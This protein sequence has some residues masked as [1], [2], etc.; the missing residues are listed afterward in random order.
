[1]RLFF[2]VALPDELR[3]RLAA[4][5]RELA[6]A[7]PL[8]RVGW[9]AP[10]NIHLTLRFQ[11][12]ASE[13]DV[14]LA[15]D[16]AREAAGLAAPLALELAGAGSFPGGRDPRVVW[17]G[18]REGPGLVALRALAGDLERGL[19]ARGFAAADHPFSPHVTLGRARPP[20]GRGA[21]GRE[22]HEPSDRTCTPGG[23]HELVR[24]L[25]R[26]AAFAGGTFDVPGFVL[27]ESTL[28]GGRSPLYSPV[29]TFALGAPSRVT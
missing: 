22:A 19:L 8:P 1:M 27:Y 29:E 4:L 20:R 6:E 14:E 16:A 23:H 2:A 11:G 12:D 25:A 17:V 24:A 21:R 26:Q 7:A 15:R 9:V 5:G 18:V 13:R 28:R 10:E 3:A